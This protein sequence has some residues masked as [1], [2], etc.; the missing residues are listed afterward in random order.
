[1]TIW[2]FFWVSLAAVSSGIAVVLFMKTALTGAYTALFGREIVQSWQ[3]IIS[4]IIIVS[5][6]SGG[7]RLHQLERYIFPNE[8]NKEQIRQLNA[9]TISLEAVRALLGGAEAVIHVLLVMLIISVLV[10]LIL[11]VKG[12]LKTDCDQ[13]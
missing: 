3:K 4:V 9:D 8:G 5:S 13:G 12:S 6:L 11:K 10:V 7:V 2:L 1:M